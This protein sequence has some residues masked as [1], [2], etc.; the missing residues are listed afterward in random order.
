MGGKG[1]RGGNCEKKKK[2]GKGRG[3]GGKLS[4]ILAA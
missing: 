2:K 3:E 1:T 4:K